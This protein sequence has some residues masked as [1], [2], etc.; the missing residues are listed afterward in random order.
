MPFPNLAGKH[1]YDALVTPQDLHDSLRAEGAFPD[2]S[3]VRGAILCYQSRI[4]DQI[5]AS[6]TATRF[7]GVGGDN[8][9]VDVGQDGAQ[10]AVCGRFGIGAPVAAVVL[11]DLIAFGVRRV[12]SVGTAGCLQ[13]GMAVGD[14]VLCTSAIRDEG[15]SYHYLEPDAPA[16]PDAA[17]TERLRAALATQTGERPL[18]AGPTWTIDAPYRETIDEARHYQSLGVQTVEMEAAALFAVAAYRGIEIASAFVVSDSL[19]E[20]VWTPGFRDPLVVRGLD[21]LY[22]A[23]VATLLAATSS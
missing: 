20:L 22:A 17:M 16:L 4:I 23:A 7:R 10:I 21:A 6:G 9:L 12:V 13:R 15:V 19:A 3:A 18:H 5:V 8:F 11:E 2:L 14:L 1:A